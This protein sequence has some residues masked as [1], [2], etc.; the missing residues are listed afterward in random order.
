M[1]PFVNEKKFLPNFPRTLHLPHNPNAATDDIIASVEEAHLVFDFPVN[2]EE[3]IDGASVGMLMYPDGQPLIR[4]R[5]HILRK[6]YMKETAAKKQFASIFNW[7]YEH[8]DCLKALNGHGPFAVYGEWCVAKHGIHYT[9][10]P[11][12]FIA[13]DVY[14][15]KQ[16][17]FL[18][19]PKARQILQ[20]CG[21][22]MPHLLK[23]GEFTGTYEDLA[24]LSD[25]PALWTNEKMEGLYLKVHDGTKVT[26]RFKMVRPDFLRGQYWNPKQLS[27]NSLEKK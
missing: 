9:R 13:Y 14:D 21:F 6:G 1:K 5:E 23:E 19:P 20:E 27:K 16:D 22:E 8:A 15:V 17:Y 3:K 12:W 7:A 2:I 25:A 26:A 24:K 11:D 18:A 4:N 10:L